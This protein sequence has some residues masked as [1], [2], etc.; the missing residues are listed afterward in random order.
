MSTGGLIK[1]RQDE[2]AKDGSVTAEDNVLT[3]L[4]KECWSTIDAVGQ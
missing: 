2:K 1:E 4:P 3:Y